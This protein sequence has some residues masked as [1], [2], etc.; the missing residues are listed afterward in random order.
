M[1]KSGI[2]LNSSDLACQRETAVRH[3]KISDILPA[4]T[5][6]DYT[7]NLTTV[8]FLESQTSLHPTL[9][10]VMHPTGKMVEADSFSTT[11]S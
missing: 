4:A 5:L 3:F 1:S 10:N 6:T 11:L 2:S 7:E 8:K 9:K